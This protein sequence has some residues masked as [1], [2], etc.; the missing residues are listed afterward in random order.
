MW[1]STGAGF[2]P[3]T[4]QRR[5]ADCNDYDISELRKLLRK[6]QEPDLAAMI[7][8]VAEGFRFL[9]RLTELE[10]T[11]ARDQTRQR[12]TDAEKLL[13]VLMRAVLD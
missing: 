10:M 1:R 9:E 3:E 12:R 13:A 5:T 6:D 7:R 4:F 8:R 2:D 11:V